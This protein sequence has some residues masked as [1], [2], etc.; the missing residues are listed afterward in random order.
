M[1]PES[2]DASGRG[3]RPLRT[4]ALAV[5]SVLGLTLGTA[6][7]LAFDGDQ[8]T[9]TGAA[10]TYAAQGT[11]PSGRGKDCP[12]RVATEPT[13][14][15]SAVQDE[16][17]PTNQV[18]SLP[19]GDLSVADVAERANPAVVTIT[20]LQDGGIQS[21]E[22]VAFGT[23]SGFIIDVEGRVVT[24]SHVV[25]EAEEMSVEFEDG[26]TVPATLV[27]QDPFQDIAV[28]QLDLSGG[29]AVPGI[30]TIGNSD[31][32]R[33]GDEV[34][35]IGSALGEFTNT[36]SAGTVGAVDRSLGGR[37]SNLIN[38]IQ[39]DAPIWRGNSGGPLLN[40]RGEVIGVNVAGIGDERVRGD[41]EQ[42]AA[43][44]IAFAIASNAASEVIDALVADG[45]VVRPFLGISGNAVANGQ[46]VGDIVAGGPADEA[47]VETGD[48]ITAID[49]QPLGGNDD[50]LLDALFEREPG[51]TVTLTVER[52]G[53]EQTIEVTL[54]ERPA[55]TQ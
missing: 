53:A 18:E 13:L 41:F 36:V 45:V 48:V 5:L 52:D 17:E 24:N 23:G 27:G 51:Q 10:T 55:E 50:A 31:A 30:L 11:T 2:H 4:A 14:L 20:N 33:P 28:I 54:G 16:P 12:E 3:S 37:G 35:S 38:L 26:T 42:T 40:L 1:S 44:Q 39:H 43:A 9:T 34:V 6:G 32:V 15:R 7:V 47:G 46:V 21:D 29:E 25:D 49:G 8:T 22:A 19:G